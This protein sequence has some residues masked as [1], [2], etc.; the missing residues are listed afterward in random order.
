MDYSRDYA[1]MQQM[2]SGRSSPTPSMISS[3]PIN[4][5]MGMP[6]TLTG[7]PKSIIY[8]PQPTDM[9]NPELTPNQPMQM[10]PPMQMQ[11]QMQPRPMHQRQRIHNPQM[12]PQQDGYLS[13]DT[14]EVTKRAL[15]YILE[16][17]AVGAVAHYI[18]RKTDLKDAFMIGLTAAFVFAILDLFAPTVG[19]GTRLGTGWAVGYGLAG[20]SPVIAAAAI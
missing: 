20:I 7:M 12:M 18:L 4:D 3:M 11:Q 9:P 6:E 13:F 1:M 15:K 10:Q 2:T 16:G 17:L 5:Q 19:T 8:Q 14:R